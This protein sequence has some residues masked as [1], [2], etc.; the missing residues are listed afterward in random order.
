MVTNTLCFGPKPE[1]SDAW[2]DRGDIDIEEIS[3]VVLKSVGPVDMKIA[4]ANAP[5][6]IAQIP[7]IIE[8]VDVPRHAKHVDDDVKV[9]AT[10]R[11]VKVALEKANLNG[12]V[13]DASFQLHRK[14]AGTRP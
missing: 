9:V 7:L 3:R 1:L 5:T 13:N 11:D 8:H 2:V 14:K 12:F 6:E 4:E 10:M